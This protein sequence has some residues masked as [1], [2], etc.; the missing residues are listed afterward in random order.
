MHIVA[1]YNLP[2]KKEPLAETLA[3]ALGATVY[4]AL[5]RLRPPGQGPL[6]VAVSAALGQAEGLLTRLKA[7]GFDAALL[8][9]DEIETEAVRF[10]VRKF[11]LGGDALIAESAAEESLALAYSSIELIIRGTAIAQ[12]TV[13]ETVK[14]KKFDPGMALL[15]SGLKM[16]KTTEK[17]L[18][19]TIQ[20]RE[21]FFHLYAGDQQKL[22]FRESGLLYNSLGTALQPTRQAN[23]AYLLA[24]LRRRSPDAFY[25]DRL[26]SRAGQVQLLG[27]SL[28]PE[29]YLDI[30][31]SLLA[32][33]LK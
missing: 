16:T 27:P 32:R 11:R 12:T 2:E 22:V 31:T 17:V 14:E 8:K 24:E 33:L 4:E 25:D 13:T 18:E 6:V 21:G 23:F 1:I 29:K 3:T 28:S 7:S 19:N 10:V 9:D 15:T 30:A 20:T 5:S 26:L